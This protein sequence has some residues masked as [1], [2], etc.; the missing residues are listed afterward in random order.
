MNRL[1]VNADLGRQKIS[2]H[3]YGNFA[4]HL[5]S[6]I[7]GGMWVGEDSSIPNLRGI[8]KDVLTALK[9]MR[10]P[11]L[12]W[13]GGCFADTYNW[14][15]GLGPR[16]DR[17]GILN[18]HWGWATENNHFGT[19]EF[20]D[21]CSEIGCDPYICGNVGS[22]TVREMAEWLEYL[23][24]PA[25]SPMANLR[26]AHGREQPW[27]IPFWAVG[28]ENWGCG[29]NMTA[30]QYAWEYR[31]YQTYC[32]AFNG[33]KLYRV[34]C[35]FEDSWNETV[36][37]EAARFMDG[38]S[39]HYYTF[40]RSWEEKGKATGFPPEEWFSLLRNALKVEDF[41]V[42]T[43]GIMDR[44]D[45]SRCVGIVLD[46]WGTWHLPEAGSNSAFLVQQNTIRDAV[47]AGASLNVFNRHADRLHV[48]NLAQ[49]VN[50][51]QAVLLTDG[52][53]MVKTP[54]Y[55]VMKMY[56]V[57]QDATLLPGYLEEG[58]YEMDGA[59]LP[60]LSA[61]ASRDAAGVIHVT[62]CNLHH[63]S[64][65]ELQIE[66]RGASPAKAAGEVLTGPKIDSMNTF[67]H[68]DAVVPR[69]LDVSVTKTGI[70]LKL[71]PRSV[72]VVAIS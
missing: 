16:K 27:K 44:F 56:A 40:T 50:V 21:L 55:H 13:P 49:T 17:K 18:V 37:R 57:H 29:G 38:L 26:R 30:Q 8:R 32:R 68:P 47:A 9:E 70:T 25:K 28:N 2:R 66:V 60:K 62:A 31:K 59:A 53:K 39:I 45:P 23:T 58:T 20:L 6:C 51:L 42:R 41:I 67:E 5:G 71:P 63:E 46:E 64:A 12:R 72:A 4:E 22:G 65:E 7:Y 61:S 1:V 54:T 35:G 36:M 52:A 3:I 48:A 10:L 24:M 43:A 19:H 11:N 33:E 34:A 15:D 69:K 14:Q